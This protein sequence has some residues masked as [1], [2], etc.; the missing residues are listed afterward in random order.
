MVSYELVIAFRN[1][2][3]NECNRLLDIE[4]IN[5]NFKDHS[6]YSRS[7]THWACFYG[8][9]DIVKLLFDKGADVHN[10]NSSGWSLIMESSRNGY[11]DI[12]EY[13][14]SQGANVN[15][16]CNSGWDSLILASARGHI[17]IIAFLLFKGANIHHKTLNGHTCIYWANNKNIKSI[18]E[19]WPTIMLIIIFEELCVYKELY[20]ELFDLQE[21]L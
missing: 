1:G 14:V 11:I 9:L 13:L 17:D 21:Y 12:V 2:N 3:H 4:K 7:L 19:N 15:D 20:G 5:I 18:I 8:Y 10:K 6:Y 16:V